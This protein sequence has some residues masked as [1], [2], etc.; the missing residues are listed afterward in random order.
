MAGTSKNKK[1]S[2]NKV[3]YGSNHIFLLCFS[4]LPNVLNSVFIYSI[5]TEKKTIIL[6]EK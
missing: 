3:M 4:I 2:M 5:A 6:E 1:I